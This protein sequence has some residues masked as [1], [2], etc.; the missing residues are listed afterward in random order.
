[1]KI[2]LQENHAQVFYDENQ[3]FI[4]IRIREG[5]SKQ[6]YQFAYEHALTAAKE[7]KVKKFLIN[8]GI[9]SSSYSLKTW[10]AV[11]FLP[12]F[13]AKLGLGVQLAVVRR[14]NKITSLSSKVV[15]RAQ[16]ALKAKFKLDFFEDD[17]KA[18]DWL[19]I[20][21]KKEINQN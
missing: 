3:E 7:N 18:V 17:E 9:S 21:V 4:E 16:N 8:E 20:A 19:T 10:F 1:M 5:I 15:E 11:Q 12:R 6:D 2:L 13:F 14:K